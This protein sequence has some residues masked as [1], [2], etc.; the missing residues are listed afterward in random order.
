MIMSAQINARITVLGFVTK[1]L[2]RVAVQKIKA[3][4]H[5]EEPVSVGYWWRLLGLT[6]SQ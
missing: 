1:I 5:A 3:E 6:P 4:M 2:T